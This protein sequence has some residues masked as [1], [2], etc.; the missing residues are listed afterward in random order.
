LQ[1]RLISQSQYRSIG[2][3]ADPSSRMSVWSCKYPLDAL[4]SVPSTTASVGVGVGGASSSAVAVNVVETDE[5]ADEP[6]D[7]AK[8][9]EGLIGLEVLALTG[10][11]V[12]GPVECR[13]A[14]VSKEVDHQGEGYNPGGEEEKVDWPVD[15]ATRE[16]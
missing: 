6:E 10:T 14:R 11:E 4:A 13:T 12:V 16:W 15:E 8:E 9:S 7:G 5:S 2:L 1:S 3:I